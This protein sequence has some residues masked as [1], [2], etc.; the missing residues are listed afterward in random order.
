M[1]VYTIQYQFIK[2]KFIYN[3]KLNLRNSVLRIQN[4]QEFSKI[5]SLCFNNDELQLVNAFV[6]SRV[7]H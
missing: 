7:T 5:I 1:L 3:N 6:L 2:M 4:Y